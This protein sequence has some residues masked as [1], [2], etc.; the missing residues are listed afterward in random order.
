MR[1]NNKQ[2]EQNDKFVQR[3]KQKPEGTLTLHYHQNETGLYGDKIHLA[4]KEAYNGREV[5]SDDFMPEILKDV[6]LMLADLQ[7]INEERKQKGL[8]EEKLTYVYNDENSKLYKEF[9]KDKYKD[10]VDFKYGSSAQ[11]DEGSYY[12]T[13]LDPS[14][15]DGDDKT[16][17]DDFYTAISRR[18]KGS[19][20]ITRKEYKSDKSDVTYSPEQD[21]STITKSHSP[22]AIKS[23]YERRK[24]VL[25]TVYKD[26]ET[27]KSEETTEVKKAPE[28]EIPTTEEELKDDEVTEEAPQAGIYEGVPVTG[29][30]VIQE[31]EFKEQIDNSSQS[32][33]PTS[34]VTTPDIIKLIIHSFN[35]FELGMTTANGEVIPGKYFEARIDS[36]NGL[37]KLP[38]FSG[39]NNDA[40]KY[41]EVIKQLRNVIFKTT[42]KNKLSEEIGK[43]L[44][45]KNVQCTFG[46]KI[47][48]SL[49]QVRQRRGRGSSGF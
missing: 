2:A 24:K 5:I 7:R 14:I 40:E 16:Y 49:Y 28:I 15:Y 23:F 37:M 46:I 32:Q 17:W 38:K 12:I 6:E 8:P 39:F 45:I 18:S 9:K 41:T 21:A 13:D 29:T 19:L 10:L 36:V 31:D 44:G 25:D 3:F 43:I 30:D 42:D 1:T 11:G 22:E 4:K 33:E 26:G 35:T 34:Q 20:I 27:V 48:R 47:F